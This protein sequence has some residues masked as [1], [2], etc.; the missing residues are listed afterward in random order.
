MWALYVIVPAILVYILTRRLIVE[1]FDRRRIQA[2]LEARSLT[3]VDLNL[4][5]FAPGWGDT[6]RGR[7]YMVRLR[8]RDGKELEVACRTSLFR[9]VYFSDESEGPVSLNLR[10]PP[11]NAGSVEVRGTKPR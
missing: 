11:S 7:T 8:D 10:T 3:L 1:Y 9:E 6:V 2:F 5:L 4:A